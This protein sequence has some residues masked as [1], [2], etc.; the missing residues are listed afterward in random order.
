[1]FVGAVVTINFQPSFNRA[2][3]V[4]SVSTG[5]SKSTTTLTV[6]W[7]GDK[8]KDDRAANQPPHIAPPYTDISEIESELPYLSKLQDNIVQES[9]FKAEYEAT[10]LPVSGTDNFDSASGKQ[11]RS[12]VDMW[13]S[14]CEVKEQ[15][16]QKLS[17]ND[18]RPIRL[19]I[20]DGNEIGNTGKLD[21]NR[22]VLVYDMRKT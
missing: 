19:H 15:P 1:M 7:G 17:G 6:T 4:Q 16:W 2:T 3:I 12:G 21:A 22:Q 10:N 13:T 11:K 18:S 8:N 14:G 20:N 5:G 9:K